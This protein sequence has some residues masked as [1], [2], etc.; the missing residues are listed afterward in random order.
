MHV[1]ACM[2]SREMTTMNVLETSKVLSDGQALKIIS[3][4][5]TKPYTVQ[6]LSEQLDSPLAGI[7]KKVK[8]LEKAGL[9]ARKDRILTNYGKRVTRYT[10]LVRGFFVQFYNSELRVTLEMQNS[11]KCVKL[12]WNPLLNN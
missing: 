3:A 11:D 10:S 8:E 2:L 9:I 4:T 7:Y 12:S 6:E 5:Q 1:C